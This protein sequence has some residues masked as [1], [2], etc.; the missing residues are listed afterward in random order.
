MSFLRS[1]LADPR[2][3]V[4]LLVGATLLTILGCKVSLIQRYGSDL[5]FWDQWD[6]E[7][8]L[9]YAKLQRG[10]L[11]A[12]DLVA[13]HNEHRIFFTRVLALGLFK[14]NG[15]WDARLQTL[16]NTLIHLA[17]IGVFLLTL[18][19]R[20]DRRAFAGFCVAA[21]FSFG[22]PFTAENT[23]S[24]FQSQFYFLLLFTLLYLAGALLH[25]FG[26][27]RWLFGHVAGACGLLSM[28]SGFL[29]PSAVLAGLAVR[30]LSARRL[31]RGGLA[32]GAGAVIL[33]VCGLLLMAP[34]PAHDALK[35]Q[36]VGEFVSALSTII[37]WPSPW[38]PAGIVGVALPW[39]VYLARLLRTR[40]W[41]ELDLFVLALGGWCIL[42]AAAVA[43]SRANGMVLSPRY[44][45]IFVFGVVTTLLV[46]LRLLQQSSGPRR[47]LGIGF[48]GWIGLIVAGYQHQTTEIHRHYLDPLTTIASRRVDHVRELVASGASR[49]GD[50]TPYVDIPYPNPERLALLL[51]RE[52]IR[53]ILPF[54]VRRPADLKNEH[55]GTGFSTGM[56]PPDQDTPP[57]GVS[58]WH[59]YGPLQR[60]T[61]FESP[62]LP[63][64]SARFLRF[65]VQGELDGRKGRL[66]LRTRS[67]EQ[68]V[69]PEG[70]GKRWRSV[71]VDAPREAYQIV[72]EAAPG[73]RFAF[74]SPVE[75][76]FGSW[77]SRHLVKGG[78]VAAW[79]GAMFLLVLVLASGLATRTRE[80]E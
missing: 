6:A 59:N 8:D 63:P 60:N 67:G 23:I 20:L 70:T 51:G 24:G 16:A 31:D 42:Q 43:Y 7:G 4:L 72:A 48:V 45:D 34:N 53:R 57:T 37:A 78:L 29:A 33:V 22:L 50:V 30:W 46:W 79:V 61:S 77:L 2:R 1:C 66:V 71:V 26:S 41:G 5:P 56:M 54:S 28:G 76:P 73:A 15:H 38:V 75:L 35:A 14:A 9:L 32:T 55:G 65:L 39:I 58:V 10:D 13:P 12:A 21:A 18:G 69:T 52:D 74:S 36:G 47:S 3:L 49:F 68:A 62:L 80:L 40:D 17:G 44:L 11:T 25:P 64:P 27:R 19:P